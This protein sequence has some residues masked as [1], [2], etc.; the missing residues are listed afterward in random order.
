MSILMKY[1]LLRWLIPAGITVAVVG[2]GA[3]TQMVTASADPS[4]PER[5][6]AQL[7]VDLQESKVEGMSGTV[8]ERADLGLPGIPSIG[9]GSGSTELMSLLSGSHTLRVWFSGPDKARIAL[10]GT[11][12][13]TDV[14]ANDND[15]W[16]WDSQAGSATHQTLEDPSDGDVSD[17]ARDAA[18]SAVASAMPT[19]PQDAAELALAALDPTTVVTTA[20]TAKVAGRSAYELV[21]APRD[22]NS[23]VAEVRIAID[24]EEQVPLRVQVYAQGSDSVRFEVAFTEVSFDRPDDEQFRFNPPEG[25]TVTE[26]SAAASDSDSDSSSGSASDSDSSTGSDPVI[27][28]TGWASVLVLPMEDTIDLDALATSSGESGDTTDPDDQ[29]TSGEDLVLSILS[30]LPEVS[31]SWGSGRVLT[32]SLFSILITDDGRILIGAVSADGLTAAAADP[33]AS[34][35]ETP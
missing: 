31:G 35:Q 3:A 5:S 32:G 19:N 1:P 10:L 26:P 16:I 6:A 25:T 13:E 9:D 21:L 24:A 18:S 27:I 11:L 12:G 22:A 8:V 23:L 17:D 28:G 20:G 29:T 4:L 7:L 34:F 30:D 2:G 14:I 33:A 15:L